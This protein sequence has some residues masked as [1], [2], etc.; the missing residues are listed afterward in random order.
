MLRLNF[1]VLV[2]HLW[3]KYYRIKK[4]NTRKKESKDSFQD[5]LKSVSV[6]LW[7]S[8]NSLSYKLGKTQTLSP[9]LEFTCCLAVPS[10]HIGALQIMFLSLVHGEGKA[11]SCLVMSDDPTAPGE[12]HFRPQTSWHPF[13]RAHAV[14]LLKSFLVNILQDPKQYPWLA[15]VGTHRVYTSVRHPRAQS[16]MHYEPCWSHLVMREA[17]EGCIYYCF[18]SG[19]ADP[20]HSAQ[21]CDLIRGFTKHLVISSLLKKMEEVTKRVGIWGKFYRMITVTAYLHST[22]TF[23]IQIIL[24]N[25][26]RIQSNSK[27]PQ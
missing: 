14:I 22:H 12:R 17:Q 26:E 16:W 19:P 24:K 1:G 21:V 25:V 20:A 6:L 5:S 13:C 3:N 4:K 18:S 11:C 23:L 15:Q 27:T 7:T 8:V 10:S 2:E 9:V